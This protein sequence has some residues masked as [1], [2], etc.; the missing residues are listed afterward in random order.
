MYLLYSALLALA[1]LVASPYFLYRALTTG[2]YWPSLKER[3][4]FLPDRINPDGRP[5]IW[6]HAVSVGE[7]LTV[8]PF[9][10][11]LRESFPEL[12]LY[13]SSTTLT[14]KDLAERQLKGVD[15]VFYCPFD[16]RFAVERVVRRVRPRLLILVE[17]E[18]WPHLIRAC[19]EAGARAM[20]VNGRISDRSFPRYLRARALIRYFLSKIDHFCMQNAR[21]AERIQALGAPSA[22]VTVTGSLKFDAAAVLPDSRALEILPKD[23]RILVAGSTMAPEEEI[24]LDVFETL[25]ARRKELLLVLAPRHPERF[26]EVTEL[27]RGRG[28]RVVR[29]S[30]LE[31][32]PDGAAVIV[33]DTMGELASVYGAGDVVF[34]GGSLAARGGHNI[35]EPAALARPI[36]FG[37]HM[38]NFA[39]IAATFLEAD[40]A[41]EVK[42]RD[43]LEGALA[44]L[45]DRPERARELGERARLLV[46]EHRGASRRTI[47]IAR[48]LLGA[49]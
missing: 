1:A 4:G 10:P 28:L 7:V 13:V 34:V 17:T 9:L 37:P 44:Q 14:G 24:L 43:E 15:G 33:L 11:L 26:D 6:V 49:S 35:L 36:V 40:A 23:R 18:I 42:G 32:V 46:E 8:R 21:Y 3:L 48:R 12:G 31:R 2:K 19:H 25:A 38:A 39:E 30:E 5:S 41:V 20:L 22:S 16:F 47:E 29:R 27:A 45:L